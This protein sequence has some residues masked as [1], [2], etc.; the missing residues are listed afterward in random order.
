[1][2]YIHVTSKLTNGIILKGAFP[3]SDTQNLWTPTAIDSHYTRALNEISQFILQ[4]PLQSIF[5]AT[6]G[7]NPKNSPIYLQIEDVSLETHHSLVTLLAKLRA[8][9]ASFDTRNENKALTE[10]RKREELKR[11]ASKN[12]LDMW[13]EEPDVV[14]IKLI[15]D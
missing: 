7:G 3:N 13:N 15:Q 12:M 6:L 14:I 2:N 9:K 4:L 5:T 1:M 11:Q 8:E 10:I